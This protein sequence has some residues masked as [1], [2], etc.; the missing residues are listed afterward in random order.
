MR[1][2]AATGESMEEEL[3]HG[4]DGP[5]DQQIHYLMQ[6]VPERNAEGEVTSVISVAR[7]IS[8][9]RKPNGAWRPA[10]AS[11]ASCPVAGKAPARRSA[12]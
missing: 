9:I 6:L 3:I 12:S 8:G 2:V 5:S 11:C 10:T 1:E 4:I 7:D